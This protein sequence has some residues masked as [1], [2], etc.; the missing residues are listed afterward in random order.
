M[1]RKISL[2]KLL[3]TNITIR[4]FVLRFL[5]GSRPENSRLDFV[6]NFLKKTIKLKNFV[7]KAMAF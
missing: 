5:A 2:Q 1:I 6:S 4:G 3:R 7:I